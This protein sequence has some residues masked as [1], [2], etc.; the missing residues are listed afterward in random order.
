MSYHC[1][2]RYKDGGICQALTGKIFWSFVYVDDAESGWSRTEKEAQDRTNV[3]V[4]QYLKEEGRKEGVYLQM[5]NKTWTVRVSY[6]MR[7]ENRSSWTED[8][9]KTAGFPSFRDLNRSLQKQYPGG[10][11]FFVFLVNKS[12]RAFASSSVNEG[13]ADAE[14][15]VVYRGEPGSILHEVLHVFGAADLYYP[16]QVTQAAGRILGE[17]VMMNSDCQVLDDLTKYLIGWHRQ[18]TAKA[19]QLLM[20]TAGITEQMVSDAL[21]AENQ[22]RNGYGR[23]T[24]SNG[25]VYEGEF[26]E[27]VADGRG[28]F[29]YTNGSVYQGEVKMG[30]PHGTGRITYASGTVYEG[31]FQNGEPNGR[32]R[33]IYKDGAVYQGDVK[34]GSFE[35]RGTLRYAG[36]TVYEGTFQ[37]HHFHGRGRIRFADG[38]AY[39]GDFQQGKRQGN[40]RYV[41][42]SGT[43]YDGEFQD[44]QFHGRGRIRYTDG[45]VYEGTFR[46][47]LQQ[48]RGRYSYASGTVYEGEFRNGEPC[49]CGIYLFSNGDRYEGEVQNGKLHGR[50]CLTY[51]GGTVRRGRF[52]NDEY[53]G[54]W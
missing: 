23:K 39:E 1:L 4:I 30:S 32:G 19:R 7:Q 36:G 44:D 40:G 31:A 20:A 33:F 27:G 22:V 26:Q 15:C 52:V 10:Q 6:A 29:Y 41:F 48:G 24:Y 16:P 35:G 53:K 50:G 5:F 43:A 45:S 12:G 14:Y 2:K 54:N 28:T 11:I 18:P 42:A 13:A 25:T 34:N 47:G 49:G 17:S 37:N 46:N 51:A 8:F 3:K 9:A 21:Q 38:A